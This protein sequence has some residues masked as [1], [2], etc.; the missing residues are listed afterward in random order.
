MNII[1]IED[2]NILIPENWGEIN[3]RKYIDICKIEEKKDTYLIEDLFIIDIIQAIIGNQIDI[4]DISISD[5]NKISEEVSKLINDKVFEPTD[6]IDINGVEYKFIDRNK[7][8]IGEYISIKTLSEGKNHY[9]VIIDILT[10]LIRPVIDG[11]IEKYD[12]DLSDSRKE[13]FLENLL[14]KDF[15]QGLSFFLNGKEISTKNTK[16]ISTQENQI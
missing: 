1:T 12:T 2:K 16:D 4:D 9:D 14:V 10:I 11:K 8:K 6:I 3:I 15:L 7:I 13:L 5:F